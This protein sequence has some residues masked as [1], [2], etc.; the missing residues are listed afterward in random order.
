MKAL[1]ENPITKELHNLWRDEIRERLNVT[2]SFLSPIKYVETSPQKFYCRRAFEEYSH[3]LNNGATENPRLLWKLLED[4]EQEISRA[5]LIIEEI[6]RKPIHDTHLSNGIELMEFI[7]SQIHFNLLNLYEAGLTELLIVPAKL[8]RTKRNKGLEGLELHSVVEEMK[9]TNLSFVSDFYNSTVRN[10]IAHGKMLFSDH[11]V[12]YFDKKG[13]TTRLSFREIAKLFDQL[14]DVVNGFHLALKLFL[15]EQNST[16]SIPLS[17]LTEEL[18]VTCQSPGWEVQDCF[19]SVAIGNRRQLSIYVLNNNWAYRKVLYYAFF[20]AYWSDLLIKNYDRIFISLK[21][22][23][24]LTGWAA[25]D[26]KRLSEARTSKSQNVAE[27]PSTL[28]DG[29]IMFHPTKT[30]PGLVYKIG[31]LRAA[32]SIVWRVRR[33]KEK[34]SSPRRVVV[35]D[36]YWHIRNNRVVIGDASVVLDFGS[37]LDQAKFIEGEYARIIKDVINHCRT[38]LN[39]FQTFFPV[40]YIQVSIFDSDQRVRNLRHSGLNE[41][42]I[43]SIRVNVSKKIVVPDLIHSEIEQQGKYTI[44]W[45]K[46]WRYN[47]IDDKQNESEN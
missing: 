11:D 30:F 1:K 10:S 45:N 15:Y 19:E 13:N 4:H 16:V 3:F 12:Q 29:G 7:R 6:N 40:D 27:L 41:N 31:S 17:M 47:N 34:R 18:K 14:L 33:L 2:T 39:F 42:T 36:V 21:S 35:R 38:Q 8:S 20:T 24:S 22:T 28:E 9:Y 37:F 43:A 46:A 23:T 26:A 5:N 32:F 25:F 44:Y